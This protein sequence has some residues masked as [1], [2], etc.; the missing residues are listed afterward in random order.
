VASSDE[1]YGMCELGASVPTGICILHRYLI[2][3]L[4]CAKCL[5]PRC[6]RHP[7][8]FT[9]GSYIHLLPHNVVF[10]AVMQVDTG[11]SEA[12][13]QGVLGHMPPSA[14]HRIFV[15]ADLSQVQGG[16]PMGYRLLWDKVDTMAPECAFS[17]GAYQNRLIR[18]PALW[19]FAL[20]T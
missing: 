1:P 6:V 13:K 20:L 11:T 14:R 17:M 7:S 18:N 16:V 8:F 9:T 3:N 4:S 15:K 12:F 5:L 19:P 2:C 10:F